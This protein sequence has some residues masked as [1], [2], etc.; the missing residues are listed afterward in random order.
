M[1]K[2][3]IFLPSTQALPKVKWHQLSLLT[4]FLCCL[5]FGCPSARGDSQNPGIF[6]QTPG[7]DFGS[8][9]A[10][11]FSD[12]DN[13]TLYS[14]SKGNCSV[15]W[16]AR[17]AE[18]GMITHRASCEAPFAVQIYLI[19]KICAELFGGGKNARNIK[20]LFWGKLET[21]SRSPFNEMSYRLA[22]TVYNSPAWDAKNGK[23]LQGDL[24]GLVKF[25]SNHLMI[26]PELQ[27]VFRKFGKKITLSS[28]EKV[29][30]LKAGKLPFYDK[31]AEHRIAPEA[32]VPFDFIA[33]FSVE[34]IVQKQ[35]EDK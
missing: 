17:N 19:E 28:I 27:G 18:P 15:T 16:M 30:V 7:R 6:F 22:L 2:H 34:D 26:Y 23:P 4:V 20:T 31:L 29:R 32:K 8:Q 21:T 33:W 25:I 11:S 12:Q 3:D 10:V 24:Y 1:P 35:Q 13:A 14:A 9:V 5:V